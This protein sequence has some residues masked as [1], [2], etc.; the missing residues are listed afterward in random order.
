[1]RNFPPLNP[2]HQQPCMAP[3]TLHD[4]LY[5]NLN[6]RTFAWY[7]NYAGSLQYRFDQTV[8]ICL[9]NHVLH[10]KTKL[11]GEILAYVA[12]AGVFLK[13]LLLQWLQ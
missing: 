11:V 5:R 2:G 4:I 13:D 1:M 12:D 7:R 3:T 10:I 8:V 9:Y 6:C